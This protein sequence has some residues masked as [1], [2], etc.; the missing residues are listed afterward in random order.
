MKA[1]LDLWNSLCL[2]HG[3]LSHAVI[4]EAGHAVVAVKHGIEF[5]DVSINPDPTLHP[6][7]VGAFTG[8]GVRLESVDHLRA[9]VAAD[10]VGSLRFCLAGALAER[11]AFEH[12]LNDSY[13][14]D[15]NSWRVCAGLRDA[16][17]EESLE[18]ALGI[19]F[20]TV[21]RSTLIE[22]RQLGRA[23]TAVAR[24]LG[25]RPTLRLSLADVRGLVEAA[26]A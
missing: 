15:L 21:S 26:G 24:A 19:P 2:R 1:S 7:E 5:V 12:T 10:P 3:G 11:A 14:A 17:T 16:Q 9:A 6:N 25:D 18:A 8:G 23:V 20:A 22:V 13:R 4:H